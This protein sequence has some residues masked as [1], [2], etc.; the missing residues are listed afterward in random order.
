MS[1]PAVRCRCSADR[2]QRPGRR[3]PLAPALQVVKS[4]ARAGSGRRRRR[5]T[6]RAAG[7]DP[8]TGDDAGS[9]RLTY[10]FVALCIYDYMCQVQWQTSVMR[11]KLSM[12]LS[13][14][15]GDGRRLYGMRA[16]PVTRARRQRTRT[17]NHDSRFTV[18]KLCCAVTSVWLKVPR[19]LNASHFGLLGRATRPHGPFWLGTLQ[20]MDS[21]DMCSMQTDRLKMYAALTDAIGL[22]RWLGARAR[23]GLMLP[24]ISPHGVPASWLRT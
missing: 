15:R 2:R 17:N 7:G 9:S 8:G 12:S 20:C 14:L 10:P 13:C 19:A 22:V 4:E 1:V 23:P 11:K 3:G 16:V 6:T 24:P 5:A 21:L 18:I